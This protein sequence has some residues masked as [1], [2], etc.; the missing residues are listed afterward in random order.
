MRLAKKERVRRDSEWTRKPQDGHK[1]G[2]TGTSA[3][4]FTL[5]QFQSDL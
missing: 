1:A 5:E 3:K 2:K 4:E